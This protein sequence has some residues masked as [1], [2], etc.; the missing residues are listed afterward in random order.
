MIGLVDVDVLHQSSVAKTC[1]NLEIMKLFSYYHREG[2]VVRLLS[3]PQDRYDYD[4]IY[5][6]Q[7]KA[8]SALSLDE[9]FWDHPNLNVGGLY[10]TNGKYKPFSNIDIE[11]ASPD[12]K[13]YNRFIKAMIN[14]YK[15]GGTVNYFLQFLDDGFIRIHTSGKLQV[16]EAD[17]KRLWIYDVD[18]MRENGIETLQ[19]LQQRNKKRLIYTHPLE[20]HSFS[21]LDTVIKNHLFYGGE[22]AV[23]PQHLQFDV[24]LSQDDFRRFMYNYKDYINSLPMLNFAI[25]IIP[26]TTK[27]VTGDNELRF[28][29]E[30]VKKVA[31]AREYGCMISALYD[32]SLRC[33]Y[34]DLL[35]IFSNYTRCTSQFKHSFAS[36]LGTVTRKT[37][38]I[39]TFISPNT[40]CWDILHSP[41]PKVKG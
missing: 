7:E 10:F 41:I 23:L 32:E 12:V 16:R 2:Q 4:T 15:K 24:Q 37:L 3:S 40:R 38:N 20:V 39:D 29:E 27:V 5:L 19:E 14:F 11:N 9:N 13:V 28:L 26:T 21:Q 8:E 6:R 18:P 31:I 33:E 35:R 22:M 17:K 36:Y 25:P 1:L 34:D 30:A